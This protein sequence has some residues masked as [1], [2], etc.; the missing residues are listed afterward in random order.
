MLPMLLRLLKDRVSLSPITP[1]SILRRHSNATLYLDRDSASLLS[2]GLQNRLLEESRVAV[3]S[4]FDGYRA[5]ADW[6]FFRRSPGHG[7]AFVRSHR[8]SGGASS[9]GWD[10]SGAAAFTEHGGDQSRIGAPDLKLWLHSVS[11]YG[12]RKIR[13]TNSRNYGLQATGSRG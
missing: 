11:G 7:H 2:A 5:E 12:R 13:G 8:D 9:A 10:D 3:S 6:L 4:Y 1:A